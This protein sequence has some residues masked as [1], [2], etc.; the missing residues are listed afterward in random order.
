MNCLQTVWCG[1]LLAS[2]LTPVDIAKSEEFGVDYFKFLDP[3]AIQS[4]SSGFSPE[5]L[6]EVLSSAM[7]ITDRTIEK[8]IQDDQRIAIRFVR[9]PS[10]PAEIKIFARPELLDGQKQ[11]FFNSAKELRLGNSQLVPMRIELHYKKGEPEEI[12]P[13]EVWPPGSEVQ[14]ATRRREMENASIAR[15][16]ELLQSWA[17]E[18]VLPVLGAYQRQASEEFAGV[19]A[20][21][22]M[23]EKMDLSKP[24]DI[25]Q[26]INHNFDY[27]RGM[28]EMSL[29]NPLVVATR[30]FMETANGNLAEASR[31]AQLHYQFL[32]R[33]TIPAEYIGEFASL[34]SLLE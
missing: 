27:W 14:Y 11:L 8:I 5:Q 13:D 34:V 10:K 17:R 24:I 30:V 29:G 6:A 19:I 7:E 21:G 23:I 4:V 26:S 3:P 22:R 32:D 12:K 31:F 1:V 2:L 15:K 16:I 25:D 20:M 9:F 33:E 28:I 18:E